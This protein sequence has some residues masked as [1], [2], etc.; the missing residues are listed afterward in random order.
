[1]KV[2]DRTDKSIT[3]GFEKNKIVITSQPFRIDII[4]DDEPV[5]S[6]NAQGLLK[7]EHYRKKTADSPAENEK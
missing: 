4:N 2:V 5:I 3:L 6:V 7:Y 1:M